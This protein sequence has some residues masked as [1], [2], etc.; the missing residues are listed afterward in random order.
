MDRESEDRNQDLRPGD[1]LEQG[2]QELNRMLLSDTSLDDTLRRVAEL[3]AAS[4]LTCDIA[5]VT[6]ITNEEPVTKGASDA[7]ARN[8]DAV[9]Y[10]SGVGP[11]LEA[12]RTNELVHIESTRADARWPAFAQAAVDAGVFSTMAVPLSVR[13][14][15][16]GAL[17]LYA[18]REQAFGESDDHVARLFADQAAIALENA[19]T[20][21]AAVKLAQQLS[22]ALRSRAPIEQAKGVLMARHGCSADDAFGMLVERSQNENRKLRLVAD[23]IL[24]ETQAP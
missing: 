24:E 19:Q 13:G 1:P 15:V 10:A 5:D 23:G 6:L 20:H 17:N 21:H 14:A 4:L 12:W 9:Q 8:L 22:I 2:V 3:A 18:F 16:I 7:R 11:C